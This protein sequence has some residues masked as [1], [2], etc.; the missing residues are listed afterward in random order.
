MVFYKRDVSSREVFF[1]APD[2]FSNYSGGKGIIN[3]YF[4]FGSTINFKRNWHFAD[5]KTYHVN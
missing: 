5:V 3:F 2:P 1:I 4:F